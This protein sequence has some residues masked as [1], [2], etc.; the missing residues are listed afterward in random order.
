MEESGRLLG[1]G[2]EA[3]VYENGEQVLKLYRA[4]A[5]K[6]AAFREAATLAIIEPFA[7]PAPNVHEVGQYN[8]R[9][10]LIMSR[11]AGSSF[12]DMMTLEPAQD[13]QFLEEMVRLHRL[14]HD[15][16]G[17]GLPGLKARLASNIRR[18]TR[19]DT[20]CQGRLLA[21]LET[22][23]DGDRLCH[24]DFH[25]W[26]IIGSPGQAVVV[27]WLDACQGIPAADVCRSYV[28]IRKA[29]QE[30][31]AAYVEAYAAASG[32]TFDDVLAW[33]PFIAAARLTEGVPN[34]E[35]ELMRL[36]DSA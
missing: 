7:L 1:S 36:A 19:L 15:Q 2:K 21:K 32:I 6:S 4:T 27:D 29:N 30:F 12:A 22:M 28:L 24:G 13:L 17:A 9:W 34:E 26:N 33:L 18:A 10:G 25:P 31:A 3:E 14:I 8:G 5:S 23:P 11:A 35:D 16:P 20:A